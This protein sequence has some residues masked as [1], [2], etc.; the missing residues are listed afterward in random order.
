MLPKRERLVAAGCDPSGSVSPPPD[1]DADP[2]ADPDAPRLAPPGG[3]KGQIPGVMSVSSHHQEDDDKESEKKEEAWRKPMPLSV[4]V[5]GATRRPLRFGKEHIPP[6]AQGRARA[7]VFEHV[8]GSRVLDGVMSVYRL[9]NGREAYYYDKGASV[10]EETHLDA[11]TPP[12]QPRTLT[13]LC[14]DQLPGRGILDKLSTPG[15]GGDGD[16]EFAPA[17][18]TC[19]LPGLHTLRVTNPRLVLEP[20]AYADLVPVHIRFVVR[21]ERVLEEKEY[22]E[23]R[24]THTREPWSI[25]KSVYVPRMKKEADSKDFWD[26]PE[27]A[28]RCAQFDWNETYQKS[29]FV[30]FLGMEHRKNKSKDAPTLEEMSEKILNAFKKYYLPIEAAFRYYASTGSGNIITM[31]LNEFS[32]LMTAC[33][34]PENDTSTCRRSDLDTIFITTNFDETQDRGNNNSGMLESAGAKGPKDA[35]NDTNS[36]TRTEFVELL[37]RIA[38]AKFVSLGHT[39]CLGEAMEM[40]CR[41]TIVANL[42]GFLSED[43]SVWRNNRL[44]TEE[45]DGVF[46]EYLE[47]MKLLFKVYRRQGGGRFS[48]SMQIE[49]FEKII[50][51]LE[52]YDA[53]CTIQGVRNAF[54]FSQMLTVDNINDQAK[55]EGLQFVEFLEAVAR[56]AELWNLPSKEEIAAFPGYEGDPPENIIDYLELV[57]LDSEME[58]VVPPAEERPPEY[59]LDSFIELLARKIFNRSSSIP[60]GEE[61]NMPRVLKIMQA[62]I[63][64]VG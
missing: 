28:E 21:Y 39:T 16:G 36:I 44:Y 62:A 43:R 35:N 52:L 29:K 17:P 64:R 1:F 61:F 33:D 2:E 34:V 30:K 40:L 48:P 55:A 49:Q 63:T 8:P 57:R 60:E 23:D 59:A 3:V 53:K 47:F 56:V 15:D 11:L 32:E 22:S 50:D 58:V 46:K 9:P 38:A 12:G 26:G 45:M 31:Q 37:V 20:T 13:D 7:L 24:L 42:P 10:Y 5:G 19:P 27:I 14:N 4:I 18:P 6:A 41:D 54:L 25:Y 51:Q